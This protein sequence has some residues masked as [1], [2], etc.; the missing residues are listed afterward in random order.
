MCKKFFLFCFVF[1]LLI[2]SLASEDCISD[3]TR[4]K[5]ENFVTYR[6]I[7]KSEDDEI[8]YDKIEKLKKDALENL[9]EHALDFEQEKC[10][11]ESL[12]F[13][14]YYEHTLNS[15]G[16]QKELRAEMKRLMKQNF[17]CLDKRKKNEICDWMYQLSG[18]VTAYY[19]TRSVAAT[20]FYGMR[21]KGFY[22]KAIQTNKKRSIS[23][24]CLGNWCFYAP[25]IFGG[26]KGKA[27]KL[28]EEALKCAEIP[29][30]KYLAYIAMSQINFENNDKDSALEYLKKAV[31]LE[32]GQ[33]ELKLISRCNE[34]GYSN[35]QY[36]RNRSG[37][38]EE[39]AEDEKDDEDK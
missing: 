29:G 27:K 15:S 3:F 39:M 13:I 12:Y 10:L 38:D 32:L 18:D 5:I 1:F 36:L 22:E 35:F 25:V 21:V 34:K 2:N 20:F 23:Y 30:E 8:A 11:L 37:I 33:K 31:D 16:N 14:E 26:G 4:K 28:F 6:V 7:L 17:E 9:P 24:V 19:M